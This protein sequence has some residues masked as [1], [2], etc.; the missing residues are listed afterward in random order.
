MASMV[1]PL[2]F[3]AATLAGAPA[4]A[5]PCVSNCEAFQACPARNPAIDCAESCDVSY[6][7]A[8]LFGCRAE[9]ETA[10]ECESEA[11][12]KCSAREACLDTIGAF[13]ACLE[14]ACDEDPEL[15]GEEPP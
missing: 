2:I 13:Q 14:A 4:C 10:I 6:E 12:D 7:L 5:D 15:C 1:R 11:E 3:A 9:L 8:D